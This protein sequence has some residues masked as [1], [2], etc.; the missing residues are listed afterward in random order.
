VNQYRETLK[1]IKIWNRRLAGAE[2]MAIEISGWLSDSIKVNVCKEVK[3]CV[4]DA[5]IVVTATFSPEA[6]IKKEMIKKGAHI[7]SVGSVGPTLSELHP[8]LMNS[9]EVYKPVSYLFR[10]SFNCHE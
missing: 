1:E 6:Y 10:P 7:M 3:S 8:D 4:E 2:K 9:S 5:D